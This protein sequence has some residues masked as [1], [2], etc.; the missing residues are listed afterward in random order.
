MK[1]VRYEKPTM[2]I[3][4]LRSEQQ[5]AGGQDG[6]CMPQ[7]AQEFTQNFYFD[8]PG[9]GWVKIETQHPDCSGIN[10]CEFYYED[11][12]KID[13]E[14]SK[15][16]QEKAI[17]AAKQSIMRDKQAFVGAHLEPDPKWS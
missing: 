8:W 6:P 10:K 14:I 7:S 16:E 9:D 3:I 2:K 1:N 4:D 17:E 13:G 5:I 15:E 12:P 11:N